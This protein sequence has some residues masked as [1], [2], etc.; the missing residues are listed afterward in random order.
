MLSNYIR[1]DGCDAPPPA[2]IPLRAGP[3]SLIILD[4]DLRYI[5]LGEDEILRRIYVAVRDPNWGTVPGTL[6]N[7]EMDVRERTF[8]IT[9]DVEHRQGPIDF[10]WHAVL[11]GEADGTITVAMDGTARSTFRRN[12]IGVCVLHPMTCAGQPCRVTHTDDT[13][14]R[15]RF[16]WRIAPHQPFK[17]IRAISHRVEPDV[18]AQVR[19]EGDVFEM[20]DQRNW[21]DASYKTYSTP[22]GLPF[23][24]TVE[25]ST[26]ITQTVTLR[27]EGA[28]SRSTG[29]RRAKPPAIQV[30]ED[31]I[32]PPPHL[33]LGAASHGKPLSDEDLDRLRALN[34]HHLRVD[35]HLKEPDAI[36]DLARIASEARILGIDLE[37]ALF[38]SD[39]RG[40][41][42]SRLLE[43]L[44]AIHP[45]VAHWLVFDED[46]T[47]TPASLIEEVRPHLEAYQPDVP[48]GG[49]THAYFTELNRNRPAVDAL[50]LVGYSLN[51][52]VHAFDN[53]SLVETLK[54]QGVTVASARTFLGGR[55]LAVTPVTFKPRFNPNATG[56]ES[57]PGEGQL[58]PQVDV[59]QMSLL[60]AGWTL[61][62]IKYLA[63]A[64][65][66]SVTYYETTGWRGVMAQA[67][68]PPLPEA[69]PAPAGSVYPLYHVLRWIGEFADG[70][71]VPAASN[72]RLQVDG[73]ALQRGNQ[74]R[75]LLANMTSE[76]VTVTVQGLGPEVSLRRLDETTANE[77]MMQPHAFQ[78]Q[79]GEQRAPHNG[80]LILTLL[81]FAV[82]CLDS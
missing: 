20:E 69:F 13:E 19:F 53:L 44:G 41:E 76:D 71:V 22:L 78:K 6:T 5:Q 80:T 57:E 40:V 70:K 37:A 32:G 10:V 23:P 49:G 72:D 8:H 75:I 67:E 31:S 50:D 74:R 45:P 2:P 35:L 82:V 24:V 79:R 60:G 52:Q 15:G 54:T 38:F 28:P 77:A 55:P 1:H 3:L 39:D 56:P 4:G 68:G 43:G 34:L 27:L 7:L 17:D 21:T 29:Q 26:R 59:R 64:G 30:T 25:A 36:A 51:P 42:I 63:E 47:T 16:P 73:L 9:Y 11:D 61:G 18:W 58:P 62:S 33:G 66:H 46:E 48:V 14:T 12:R 65:V 81:P